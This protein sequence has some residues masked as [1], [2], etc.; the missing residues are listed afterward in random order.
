VNPL[1]GRPL[2]SLPRR[3]LL[4]V[5]GHASRDLVA[6]DSRGWRLGGSVTYVSLTAARLGVAVRALIG[7]DATSAEASE[8]DLLRNAG[9]EAST[10]VFPSAPVFRNVETPSGRRQQC[11]AVGPRLGPRVVPQAWR[12][13]GAWAFVPVLAE[14]S[15][16][17]WARFPPAG[18]T[19][20]VGWQG[21]LRQARAGGRTRARPPRA[22]PLLERADVT[23]VSEDDL[24]AGA[25]AWTERV[26]GDRLMSFFRR[27]GQQLVLT[28]AERGGHLFLRSPGSWRALRYRAVPA[29]IADATGAGDVFLAA[30]LATALD[31]TLVEPAPAPDE[32]GVASREWLGRRL[33]LAAVA[34]AMASEGLGLTAIPTRAELQDRLVSGAG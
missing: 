3:P 18:A 7:L 31:P 8:L 9:V 22:D 33:R 11:L 32:P 5:V 24:P 28:G 13:D 14:I 12:D 34:A 23:V 6:D 25:S 19:V 26:V 21:L 2:K 16:Q 29:R 4:V 30:F 1:V 10:R 15:G 27:P 17:Q 20:A